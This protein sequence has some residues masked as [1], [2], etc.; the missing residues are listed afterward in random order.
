MIRG[1]A[2]HSLATQAAAGQGSAIRSKALQTIAKETP[3]STAVNARQ[4]PTMNGSTVTGQTCE[5]VIVSPDLA[6]EWLKRAGKNFR[7]LDTRVAMQLR[8]QIR[9]NGWVNDGNTIKFDSAGNLVDGQHRLRAIADLGVTV[10]AWVLRGVDNDTTIDTGLKRSL[11]QQ[12]R[13]QK[14]VNA[15]TLGSALHICWFHDM[16]KLPTWSTGST[17]NRPSNQDLITYLASNPGVRESVAA[18]VGGDVVYPGGHMAALHFLASRA[19]LGDEV[20]SFVSK[21]RYGAGLAA[22][23][24]AHLLRERLLKNAA[25]RLKLHRRDQL[26]LVI[27]AWNAWLEGRAMALLKWIAVGPAAE[28]FPAITLVRP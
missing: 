18:V 9:R 27:K 7:K 14:E 10:M 23:D 20:A 3:M 19:G 2:A 15:T 4:Y 16:A 1:A 11:N 6:R 12:L 5:A 24:P 28:E 8:E 26:A 21:V 13:F 17:E 22:N 25:G